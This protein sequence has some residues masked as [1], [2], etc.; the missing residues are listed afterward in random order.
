MQEGFIAVC[1]GKAAKNREHRIPP[2]QGVKYT[3]RGA[4]P[5]VEGL[6]QSPW[7]PPYTPS[8]AASHCGL[9]PQFVVGPV[10]SHPLQ[11]H[12][13]L[14]LVQLP[15]QGSRGSPEPR[16]PPRTPLSPPH[17]LYSSAG[18]CVLLFPCKGT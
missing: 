15:A 16:C 11:S 5:G 3:P 4:S 12:E 18:R 7:A 14:P 10:V 6:F 9:L 2:Q 13:G 17:S 8:G 1:R